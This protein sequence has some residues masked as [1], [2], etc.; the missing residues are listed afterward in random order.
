MAEKFP[1]MTKR[2]YQQIREQLGLSNYALRSKLGRSLTQVYAYENGH[3][4]IPE[5]VAKLLLMFAKHGIPDEF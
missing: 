3:Q 2:K 4:P 5:T 1:Q